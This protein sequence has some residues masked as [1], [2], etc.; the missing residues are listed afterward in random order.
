MKNIKTI[1][2]ASLFLIGSL[3]TSCESVKNTNNTQRG[4]AIGAVGG[5]VIGGV[6]GNNLGKGGKGA[7]GAVIGGVVGGVAGGL[8]GNKMDKQAREIETALPGAQVERVGEGIKL[9]LGENSVR[10]NTDKSSLTPTAKANLDKLVP[11]FN[12][13]PDTNIQIFGYTDSTGTVEH[14][15]KLSEQR[16]ASVRSYLNG[17]GI[18]NSRFTTTGL[19]IADPIAS[20]ETVE[21]RSQNRRV[22]F[23]ITAN[24]KMVQDAQKQAGK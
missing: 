12:Q 2:L 1:A 24:E 8:I 13:Y 23:A 11:V 6:L 15:L 5:A 14:N 9:T 10:F 4:A 21:G 18:A 20:N 19:G 22:E 3:F 7:L 16:A 17:K